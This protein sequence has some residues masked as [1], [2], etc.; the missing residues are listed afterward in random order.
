MKVVVAF[1]EVSTK[2]CGAVATPAFTLPNWKLDGEDPGTAVKDTAID[3]FTW[4]LGELQ[5][6]KIVVNAVMS[7]EET[8]EPLEFAGKAMP[9][10][11]AVS[12]QVL[13]VT[14]LADQTIATEVFGKAM[15]GAERVRAAV[16]AVPTL[17]C[18]ETGEVTP[19]QVRYT[20]VDTVI[21]AIKYA[22]PL[23]PEATVMG[24]AG[25]PV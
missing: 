24:A 14:L 4:P 9:T 3:L 13:A 2:F 7:G 5:L 19:E 6:S 22:V 15:A 11:L 8:V 10:P 20:V 1:F 18:A 16:G 25:L 17:I 23:L 21:F 12:T